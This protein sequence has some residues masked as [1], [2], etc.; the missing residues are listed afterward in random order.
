MWVLRTDLMRKGCPEQVWVLLGTSEG[1]NVASSSLG[2][3][4]VQGVDAC[5]VSV[6]A[7]SQRLGAPHPHKASYS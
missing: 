3:W 1:G 2:I 5:S 7:G 6:R 4:K